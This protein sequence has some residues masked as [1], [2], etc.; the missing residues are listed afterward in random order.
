ME[1]KTKSAASEG[2]ERAQSE[3]KTNRLI[4]GET[5]KTGRPKGM[6]GE[7][8]PKVSRV[9]RGDKIREGEGRER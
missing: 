2:S 4:R 3:V 6:E 1:H 5:G 9:K 7:N 8:D